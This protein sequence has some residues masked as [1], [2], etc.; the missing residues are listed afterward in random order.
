MTT[1]DPSAV[2]TALAFR[3]DS[4]TRN[5]PDSVRFALEF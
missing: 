3:A 2:I 1:G 5:F 4:E